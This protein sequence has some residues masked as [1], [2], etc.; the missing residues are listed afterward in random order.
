M[1][2]ATTPLNDDS[3]ARPP[4]HVD[5]SGLLY[6]GGVEPGPKRSR[7]FV[8]GVE[9]AA[10]AGS[11]HA[12]LEGCLRDLTLDGRQEC[13]SHSSQVQLGQLVH[14]NLARSFTISWI[15]RDIIENRAKPSSKEFLFFLIRL[16]WE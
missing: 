11:D 5:L 7:A 15:D 13:L 4:R 16:L 14:A 12:G 6:F 8:Q 10:T 9:A 2:Q 1:P 3:T